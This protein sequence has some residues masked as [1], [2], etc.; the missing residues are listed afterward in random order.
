MNR[1]NCFLA[2]LVC[3]LGSV[4]YAQQISIDNTLSS[5][6]FIESSLIEDCV[7]VSNMS[8][9]VNGTVMPSTDYWFL[10][11]VVKNDIQFEV[12]GYLALRM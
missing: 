9:S 6:G 2:L 7:E 1:F 3:L 10:A 8:V 11:N 5:K 4:V 12:K